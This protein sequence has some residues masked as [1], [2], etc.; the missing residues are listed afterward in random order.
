MLT[1]EFYNNLIKIKNIF[2]G[3][4]QHH[5]LHGQCGPAKLGI[6]AQLHVYITSVCVHYQCLCTL[7][8][9]GCGVHY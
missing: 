5:G 2:Y 8:I 7:Y 9:T 6:G 4:S 3:L 1:E